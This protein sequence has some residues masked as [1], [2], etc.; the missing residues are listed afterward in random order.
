[1]KQPS[2]TSLD[3]T[4]GSLFLICLSFIIGYIGIST[5]FPN[6]DIVK[7]FLI[8]GTIISATGLG[9]LYYLYNRLFCVSKVDITKQEKI[10]Y[11][12]SEEEKDTLSWIEKQGKSQEPNS[13]Y[14]ALVGITFSIIG[15]VIWVISQQL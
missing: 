4:I 8:T 9:M 10:N 12:N 13:V 6:E 2:N 7:P 3:L 11:E 1:M 14:L 15:I 5:M